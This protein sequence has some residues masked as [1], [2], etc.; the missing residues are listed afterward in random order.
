MRAV[1]CS[2][3]FTKAS[4]KPLVKLP[5]WQ[6]AHPNSAGSGNSLFTSPLT[7]KNLA[8]TGFNTATWFEISMSK[9][10]RA[11][12]IDLMVQY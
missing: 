12:G 7:E 10:P 11:F 9:K 6:A 5:P 1:T 8:A 4:N 2:P 3:R